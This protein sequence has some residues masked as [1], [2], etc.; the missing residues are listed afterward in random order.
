MAEGIGI[1]Q[2]A[3]GGSDF[4]SSLFD[5]GFAWYGMQRQIQEN[6]RAEAINTREFT[7][8]FDEAI[9]QFEK[10]FGLNLRSQEFS[11]QEAK[12]NREERNSDRLFNRS[13]ELQDRFIN[14]INSSNNARTGMVN[15]FG[16]RRAI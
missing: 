16:A 4:M 14:T 9:R 15:M 5:M 10:K 12:L 2:I 1:G 8:Q 7:M 13:R 6:R 3:Q 11:E